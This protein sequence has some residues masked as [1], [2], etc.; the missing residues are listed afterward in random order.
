MT[1]PDRDPAGLP[2]G[3]APVSG[4]PLGATTSHHPP[5]PDH[6]K[7]PAPMNSSSPPTHPDVVN[8]AV[9]TRDST[10]LQIGTLHGGVAIT[11]HHRS[12]PPV[13]IVSTMPPLDRLPTALCGR[14]DLLDTLSAHTARQA[15]AL[16]VLHGVGGSG[17]TTAALGAVA[18]LDRLHPDV[19]VWWLDAST[20]AALSAGFREVALDAGAPVDQVIAAWTGSRSP[21]GVLARALAATT[22]RWLIVVDNADDTRQ[23]TPW[24][25]ALPRHRGATVITSRDGAPLAWPA[26]AARHQVG[27]LADDDAAQL[28]QTLAPHSGTRQQALRLAAALGG[29]PLALH[30]AGHYLHAARQL[31]PVHGAQVP[32]DFDQYRTAFREH[33]PDV[34]HLHE[35]T[36]GLPDRALLHRTWELTLDHLTE[37]GL[38]HA[39]PLLRWLACFAPAA[40]PYGALSADILSRS[41]LFPDITPV[42]LLRTL[43][44]LTD[45]GLLDTVSYRDPRAST[46]TT[47]CLLLH[48]VVREANRHQPDVRTGPRP[49]LALSIATLDGATAHLSWADPDERSLWAALAP[50]CEHVVDRVARDPAVPDDWNLFTTRLTRA[51]ALLAQL[52]NAPKRARDLFTQALAT[53]RQYLDEHHPDILTLRRDLAWLRCSAPSSAPDHVQRCFTELVA[54]LHDCTTHL[55]QDHALTIA[56]RFDLAWMSSTTDPDT[57][58]VIDHHRQLIDAEHRALGRHALTG[59]VA[60]LTIITT[61][62]RRAR[63][64][65]TPDTATVLAEFTKLDAMMRDLREQDLQHQLPLPLEQIQ[66]VINHTFNTFL[67]S[68]PNAAR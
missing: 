34:D 66:A 18:R 46:A 16:V 56:C 5:R 59:L 68:R 25:P 27:P 37:R 14:D 15:G 24:L 49:Y 23:L 13:S 6:W 53:R 22:R 57:A 63:H 43:G 11:D 3:T 42:E 17:K 30:L 45:F 36:G 50:H 7:H 26:F 33:F 39:R 31:P 28:L 38:H 35:L 67:I 54:L 51:N 20:D 44:A 65:P 12:E 2:G 19:R 55:G 62:W 40:L 4:A 10:M 52:T 64:S 32:M 61:L 21:A 47:R 58:T 8:H 9:G 48:P 29:L 60:Q 41:P 1:T